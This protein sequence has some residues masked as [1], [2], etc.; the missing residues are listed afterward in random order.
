MLYGWEI[1]QHSGAISL[2]LSA[3]SLM[4][5]ELLRFRVRKRRSSP[6]PVLN[7]GL[8]VG[9][10]AELRRLSAPT[11]SKNNLQIE[12]GRF[13]QR[14]CSSWQRP[15]AER[16]SC[17]DMSH[18]TSCTWRCPSAHPVHGNVPLHAL[19]TRTAQYRDRHGIPWALVLSVS[20][21]SP[22]L[23]GPIPWKRA[24]GGD[25]RALWGCHLLSCL[26]SPG[27]GCPRPYELSRGSPALGMFFLTPGIWEPCKAVGSQF[28]QLIS[29]FL[30]CRL[31]VISWT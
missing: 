16:T 7:L 4:C 18:C 21:R 25:R 6:A 1:T 22:C 9:E 28:S 23:V 20:V 10:A 24:H 26:A 19:C 14:T 11:R 31:A 2:L 13:R 30:P 29:P 5:T 3:R 17:A 8:I 15:C 12:L 27:W